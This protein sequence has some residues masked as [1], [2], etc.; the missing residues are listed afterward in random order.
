MVGN[1]QTKLKQTISN[2]RGTKILAT[3][4][5]ATD[6]YESVYDLIKAGANGIRLNFSHGT[7]AE[8]ERQIRWV[9]KA[10]DALGCQ[11]AIVQDLQGPKIRLGDF[12]GVIE[13]RRGQT[14]ALELNTDYGS[15]GHIPT[16]Y[17][18]S[19]K[20]KRGERV[21]LFDGRIRTEVSAIK[22][23]VVYVE[24]LNSGTVIKRKGIN[25]PDTD[26]GGDQEF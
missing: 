10:A 19:T 17:D 22:D 11:V 21:L 24:A 2:H 3:I 5:P 8:K 18:L 13:V 25:V 26:F 16:Q 14:L 20:V 4:G 12:E 23:G 9:R 1:K 7:F 6:S 15:S